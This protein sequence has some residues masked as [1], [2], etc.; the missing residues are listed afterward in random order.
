LATFATLSKTL[1]QRC[2]RW[3]TEAAF[4]SL[5]SDDLQIRPIDHHTEA[6]VRAHLFLCML[7][8]YVKWHMSEAWR[9]L[10]FADEDQERLTQRDPVAPA[11]R[12]AA[13][14]ENVASKPLADGSPAHSFRTLLNELS[15]IVRNTCRHKHAGADAGTFEIDTTPNPKQTAAL[16]LIKVIRL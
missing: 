3:D 10:L 5:K 4:R 1:L 2:L 9:G 13:A 16:D 15:T 6:R 7:A 11:T 14:V 12:S 8:Y